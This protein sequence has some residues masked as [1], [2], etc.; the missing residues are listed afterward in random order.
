MERKTGTASTD[1]KKNCCM[2]N[3]SRKL[4]ILWIINSISVMW[5]L[6]PFLKNHASGGKYG[7][8]FFECTFFAKTFWR[9]K[10]DRNF[11]SFLKP[12]IK[13]L[14]EISYRCLLT[15]L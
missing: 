4:I 13:L 7:Y 12:F 3:G 1:E 2:N 11:G 8:D 9:I 14:I 6:N 10:L 15:A 5:Y